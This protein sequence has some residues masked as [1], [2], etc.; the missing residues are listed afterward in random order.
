MVGSGGQRAG[1]L[2][3]RRRGIPARAPALFGVSREEFIRL[4]KQD[5]LTPLQIG[6]RNGREPARIRARIVS[7]LRRNADRAVTTRSSPPPQ[8]RRMLR[9]QLG[10][11][12]RWLTRPRRPHDVDSLFDRWGGNGPHAR[13]DDSAPALL[14]P[15]PRG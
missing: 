11:L 8:A 5:G 6:A 14:C 3:G 2:Y 10:D 12:D 4:R 9:L 7:L 13:G 15:V 1:A